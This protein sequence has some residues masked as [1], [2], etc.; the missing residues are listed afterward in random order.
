MAG[1]IQRMATL[2][3]RGRID[4]E[5]VETEIARLRRL[6]SGSTKASDG[7]DSLL[8]ATALSE[9]DTFDRVQ[10]SEV[11]RVC[12]ES[13]SL[14]DAGRQLFAASL[15]RRTSGNDADRLR[16]YLALFGLSWSALLEG[17]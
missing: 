4:V 10:L 8:S 12:R 2:S 16:K 1:D 3:P 15:S 6:W 7:L 11:V 13:R 14:S 17:R 9:L 5:G